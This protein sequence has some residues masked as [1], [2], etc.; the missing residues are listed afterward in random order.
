MPISTALQNAATAL[1]Q[2]QSQI[3]ASDTVTTAALQTAY[4]AISAAQTLYQGQG[5]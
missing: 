5:L 3:P 2:A 4:A 1:N